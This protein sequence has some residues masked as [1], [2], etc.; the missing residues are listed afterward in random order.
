M[1]S[2]FS[3]VVMAALCL[4]SFAFV[5]CDKNEDNKTSQLSFSA[6][7]TE[8]QVGNTATV[9]VKNG[10]QPYTVKSGDEKVATVKVDKATITVT[11]VAAGK[12]T[13]TVTDKNSLTGT[14]TVEV[15]ASS[16]LEFDKSSVTVG[17]GKTGTVT[18]KTGTKPFTVVVT[19]STSLEFDK[20]SV[21][22]GVGKEGTVTVKTGTQPYTVKVADET[23]ATATLADAAITVMGVKAGSTKITVTDKDSKTGEITVKVE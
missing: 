6:T 12:A 2:F 23:V 16:A 17:V 1:K 3:S 8:A 18:V 11:G 7:K 9:T 13:V 14:F 20:T 4:G 22:V 5:S 21:T 19:A 15:N 10:T